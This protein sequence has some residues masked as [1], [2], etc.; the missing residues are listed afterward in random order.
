MG[1]WQKLQK[2]K[3]F[4]KNR[5]GR[6]RTKNWKCCKQTGGGRRLIQLL[7]SQEL[8]RG[9]LQESKDRGRAAQ[10]FVK[11]VRRHP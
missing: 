1:G 10:I 3:H 11:N 8:V 4:W 2:I 6:G 7:A 5:G 9:T